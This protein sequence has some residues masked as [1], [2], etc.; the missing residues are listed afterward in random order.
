LLSNRTF[1][2]Y[3]K[4]DANEL[5]ARKLCRET[6]GAFL[7]MMGEIPPDLI[8]SHH[9]LFEEGPSWPRPITSLSL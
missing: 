9:E 7:A 2:G 1:G 8:G 6:H 4:I 5:A 3:V